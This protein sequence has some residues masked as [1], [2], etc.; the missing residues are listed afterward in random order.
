MDLVKKVDQQVDL[1]NDRLQEQRIAEEQARLQQ[2]QKEMERQKMLKEQEE[3]KIREEEE[4]RRLKAEME[5]RRKKEEE[6]RKKQVPQNF[7]KFIKKFGIHYKYTNMKLASISI[8][9]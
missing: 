5:I 9:L 6:Q 8:L 4:M 3:K 7:I 2:I 1:L